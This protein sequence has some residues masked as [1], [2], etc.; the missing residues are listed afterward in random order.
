MY[1]RYPADK[2]IVP[3]DMWAD[4]GIGHHVSCPVCGSAFAHPEGVRTV[5][6][7]DEYS[8][9]WPGRGDLTVLSFQG[10]CGH[11]WELCFGFHKGEVFAFSRV[12]SPDAP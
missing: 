9:S 7:N 2:A 12:F 6:G 5:S 11:H 4:E 8:A 1:T 10:E 3:S